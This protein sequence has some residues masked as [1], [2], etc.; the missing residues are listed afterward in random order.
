MSVHIGAAYTALSGDERNWNQSQQIHL[1]HFDLH[2]AEGSSEDR[3]TT[4]TPTTAHVSKYK[5]V[6]FPASR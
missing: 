2:L 3:E 5:K 4:T 1:H 6:L